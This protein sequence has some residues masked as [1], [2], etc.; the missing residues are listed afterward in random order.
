MNTHKFQQK[1]KWY[2]VVGKRKQRTLTKEET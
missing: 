1:P 2:I